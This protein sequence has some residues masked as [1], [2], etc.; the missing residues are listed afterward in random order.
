MKLSS[1]SGST[2]APGLMEPGLTCHWTLD[3][4]ASGRRHFDCRQ[5]YIHLWSKDPIPL[6]QTVSETKGT[7]SS[8]VFRSWLWPS[9][10]LQLDRT[11][12]GTWSRIY[13]PSD[14]DTNIRS[15]LR[16]SSRIKTTTF[17]KTTRG[18]EAV[19][20]I[21]KVPV[22]ASQPQHGAASLNSCN[23][24]ND[25]SRRV[26]CCVHLVT[27]NIRVIWTIF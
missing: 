5:V 10:G 25:S 18:R 13:P 4:V 23:Q 27:G 16:G 19:R 21:R 8:I 24:Q 11:P 12:P 20:M 22:R 15:Q 1:V 6:S 26:V 9:P 17:C 3:L 14:M 2:S 7:I